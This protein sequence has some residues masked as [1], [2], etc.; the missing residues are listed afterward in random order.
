MTGVQ[1]I[2]SL[3]IINY[4]NKQWYL[5]WSQYGIIELPLKAKSVSLNY[6]LCDLLCDKFE[7]RKW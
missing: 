2:F 3:E 4:R 5:L 1:F 6:S 7:S